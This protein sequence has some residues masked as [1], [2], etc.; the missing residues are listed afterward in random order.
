MA[1]LVTR[2]AMASGA[3]FL[4]VRSRPTLSVTVTS[5]HISSPFSS[6]S[7]KTIFSATRLASMLG[8]VESQKPL[9]SAIASARLTSILALDSSCWSCLSLDFAVPR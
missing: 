2:S 8:M 5:K 6:S 1:T 7:N 9:H 3:R 4:A